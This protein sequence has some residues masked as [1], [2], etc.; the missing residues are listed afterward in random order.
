MPSNDSTA[1]Q[2]VDRTKATTRR[3]MIIIAPF[4]SLAATFTV[5]AN[6]CLKAREIKPFD[7]SFV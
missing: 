2:I 5:P 7:L 3:Y 1:L 6:G 4:G